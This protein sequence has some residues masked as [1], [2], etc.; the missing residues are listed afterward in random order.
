MYL[1]VKR[2]EIKPGPE[3]KN[4]HI[5]DIYVNQRYMQ[6]NATKEVK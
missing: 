5:T 3:E 4:F 6:L 1:H 2:C